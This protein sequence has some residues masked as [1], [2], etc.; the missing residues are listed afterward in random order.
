ALDLESPADRRITF[1]GDGRVS[2][3][4]AS[5]P[6]VQAALGDSIGLGLAGRWSEGE[7]VELA[8]FRLAGD[9]ISAT[10]AGDIADFVFDGT[11]ALQTGGVEALAGI[12]GRVLGGAVN[13][14]ATGTISRL[15]G[16]FALTLGGTGTNL[17]LGEDALDAVLAGEVRLSGRLARTE[18]GVEAEDFRVANRQLTIV[19]DGAFASTAADFDFRLD[20]AD[21]ALLTDEASGALSVVGRA[22]GTDGPIAI[23]LTA[24]VA[25]GS[26]VA[27]PLREAQLVLA[28][29]VEGTNFDGR[30][31]GSAFLNGHLVS[32]A[33]GL[34]TDG[35][36]RRLS[37]LQFETAGTRITGDL[38]QTEEGLFAGTIAL[39]A[40]D[41]SNAAALLL[42]EAS[43]AVDATI[44]LQ[45]A[46]S[47]QSADV[48]ATVRDFRIA[49]IAVGAADVQA[50]G[51]DLFGV[52]MLDGTASARDVAAAG[53]ELATLDAGA[54][55]DGNT[56]SFTA[57]AALRNG[58]TVA[59]AGGLAA[60]DGGYRL[61]LDRA[62][63]R[64]GELTAELAAPT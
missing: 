4:V 46:G 58:T 36:Q 28:G 38:A 20:L 2:G 7:P 60:I 41:V 24:G 33:A 12:A 61:A 47:E 23:E 62:A 11:A 53:I 48:T 26:L 30:V 29:T 44:Q 34:A 17:Q 59:A 40:T 39:D 13:L 56:T 5:E 52:P 63:L 27:R 43:G 22:N 18:A 1:N 54:S 32:L 15:T 31:N 45:A 57:D 55:S 64:Q 37:D 51:T 8:E 25:S 50:S 14:Q 3:I 10:L 35:E 16:G 6:A 21:L 49:D 9:A 42:Q 19:A